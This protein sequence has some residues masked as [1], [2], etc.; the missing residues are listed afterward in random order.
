[1][2]KLKHYPGRSELRNTHIHTQTHQ[3]FLNIFK[4][5]SKF[6]TFTYNLYIYTQMSLDL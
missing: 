2:F 3:V 4:E 6:F 1:M 5:N